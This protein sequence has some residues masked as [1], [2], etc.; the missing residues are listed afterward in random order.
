MCMYVDMH[1]MVHV[2]KSEDSFLSIMW[3]QGIEFT[4]LDLE[5]GIF[6]I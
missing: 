4:S 3:V 1:A 5:S 6:P 2:W